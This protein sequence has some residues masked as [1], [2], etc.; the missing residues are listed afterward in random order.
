[1]G[2]ANDYVGYIL[3]EDQYVKGGYES[4]KGSF[5][6][7]QFGRVMEEHARKAIDLLID[8]A[9]GEGARE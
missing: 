2:L 1:V 9:G 7:P 6:G 4:D 3:T 8:N 5:Y